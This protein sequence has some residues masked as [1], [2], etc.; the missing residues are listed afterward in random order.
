M[1]LANWVRHDG[2]P[3]NLALGFHE[4]K[5]DGSGGAR[6]HLRRRGELQSTTWRTPINGVATTRW[7]R[8]SEEVVVESVV[9]KVFR[10]FKGGLVSFCHSHSVVVEVS[11]GCEVEGCGLRFAFRLVSLLWCVTL[12]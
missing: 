11:G 6:C 1:I 12:R 7:R 8:C 5:G 10:G 3:W 9:V 4:A 2:C